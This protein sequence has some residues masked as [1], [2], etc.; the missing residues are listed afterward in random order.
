LRSANGGA[1]RP[2]RWLAFKVV[3]VDDRAAARAAWDRL[4]ADVAMVL[5]T[6]R[7]REFVADLLPSRSNTIWT[8]IP[9]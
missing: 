7:A 5:L 1:S 2:S 4:G 3:P 6:A 8:L 9:D